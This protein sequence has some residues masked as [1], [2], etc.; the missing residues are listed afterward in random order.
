MMRLIML[1]QL[2]VAYGDQLYQ[3]NGKAV[4]AGAPAHHGARPGW[5]SAEQASI[6]AEED[7]LPFIDTWSLRDGGREFG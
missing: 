2:R 5:T 1:D 7:L 3:K 6:A 4:R